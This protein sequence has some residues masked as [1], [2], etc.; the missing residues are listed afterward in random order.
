MRTLGDSSVNLEGK[1][2][3]CRVD[4]NVPLTSEGEVADDERIVRALPTLKFLLARGA[5]VVVASHLGRP[6]GKV[7][8][9]YTLE[10]VAVRLQ[11]LLG[12]DIIF[13][14]DCVGDGIA[15]LVGRLE[16]GQILLLENLRFHSGEE[17]GDEGFARQLADQI[18][19]FVGDAFG[20]AHRAHASVTGLVPHVE[21][22]MAG[23]L[24]T[25][26]VEALSEMLHK[27]KAPFAAVLGGAKVSDKLGVL[28]RLIQRVDVLLIGGA[29]AYT[30]LRAKGEQIGVS[31]VEE[32]L[33]DVAQKILETAKAR[34]VQVLLPVD[35]VA[36]EAFEANA[37]NRVVLP[38]GFQS[39]EMGLDIGPQTQRAYQAA[40]K[41]A[42]TIFWNGPMGVF[43]W[44]AFSGGTL[45]VMEAVAESSAFTVVGGGDSVA[46]LKQGGAQA[47]IDHVSTGGGAGLEFLETG[48]LPGLEV[49]GFSAS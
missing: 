34:G 27:P 8:K 19:V 22:S 45:A 13:A 1:R 18:D 24:M 29:M 43:E 15:Q 35:H 17:K 47:R 38:N 5:K 14:E 21:E 37:P 40:L 4:F 10:P 46:A 36:A 7:K 6:K 20:A 41:D 26:E 39:T 33:I 16:N 9:Q 3:F 32:D 31:R 12:N 11:R 2:V 23:L 48:T 49:L 44:P 28:K 25:K 30:F 42:G